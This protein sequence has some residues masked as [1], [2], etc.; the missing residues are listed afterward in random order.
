MLTVPVD[1]LHR[2]VRGADAWEMTGVA[3]A[4]LDVDGGDPAPFRYDTDAVEVHDHRYVS[5]LDWQAQQDGSQ[6]WARR[7]SPDPRVEHV[8]ERLD[9]GPQAAVAG[10][11]VAILAA[12]VRRLRGEW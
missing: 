1:E 9:G 3:E 5:R 10:D 2:D 8:L 4:W 6:W 7:A 11:P 12:E